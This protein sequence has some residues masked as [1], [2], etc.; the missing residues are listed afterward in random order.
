[1][2]EAVISSNSGG[3]EYGQ[4]SATFVIRVLEAVSCFDPNLL[5]EGTWLCRRN[6]VW[7]WLGVGVQIFYRGG[8]ITSKLRLVRLDMA[9]LLPELIEKSLIVLRDCQPWF[10][11]P[12][13]AGVLFHTV[14]ER[15]PSLSTCWFI[16]YPLFGYFCFLRCLCGVSGGEWRVFTH[17]FAARLCSRRMLTW[18]M[19]VKL[20]WKALGSNHR[21]FVV[22]WRMQLSLSGLLPWMI[23]PTD[24]TQ[25]H[26]GNFV[27]VWL[28]CIGKLP[29]TVVTNS[30][31]NLHSTWA[32]QVIQLH[33]AHRIKLNQPIYHNNVASSSSYQVLSTKMSPHPHLH[34]SKK[35]K[36]RHRLSRTIL[37]SH[38]YPPP[39]PTKE[40]ITAKSSK[41]NY[42]ATSQRHLTTI[43]SSTI[44]KNVTASNSRT[45]IAPSCS[46]EWL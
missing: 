45:R 7:I 43:V 11:M 24:H 10:L 38:L 3:G 16:S 2:C 1:M 18:I 23:G 15:I 21:M 28:G 33:L 22:Q 35:K 32:K 30:K 9:V 42:P 29:S 40:F 8:L 20:L 37:S 6:Y 36:H 13:P 17:S 25:K 27:R 14:P 26:I 41:A 5:S 4:V 12:A 46:P 44:N 39:A 31:S 19:S 34:P